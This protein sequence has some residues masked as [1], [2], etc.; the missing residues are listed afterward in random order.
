MGHASLVHLEAFPILFIALHA[1]TERPTMR[2]AALVGLATTVAWLFS[3]YWGAMA[4]IGVVAFALAVSL[5]ARVLTH[6]AKRPGPTSKATP[7]RRR[8]KPLGE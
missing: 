2:R 8:R 6:I 7:T 1:W 4:V 3:G 5:S